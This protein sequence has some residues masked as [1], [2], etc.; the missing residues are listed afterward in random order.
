M[1]KE[2]EPAVVYDDETS[3]QEQVTVNQ[4]P[5][6]NDASEEKKNEEQM[7]EEPKEI[8]FVDDTQVD[9]EQPEYQEKMFF[10]LLL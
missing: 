6:S 1:D 4:E 8:T 5:P 9:E 2:T 7:R 3:I 10:S